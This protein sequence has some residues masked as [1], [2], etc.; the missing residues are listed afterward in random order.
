MVS[1]ENVINNEEVLY[2]VFK[3]HDDTV[4]ASWLPLF[5]DMGLIFGALHPIYGGF[6]VILMNPTYFL[7]KPVRWLKAISKYK[8]NSSGGPNFSYDL[9]VDNIKDEEL[10][11]IDLSSWKIAYN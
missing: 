3:H 9:C 1:H 8:A 2:K 11:G 4:C 7:Q 10:E 6:P 5:H